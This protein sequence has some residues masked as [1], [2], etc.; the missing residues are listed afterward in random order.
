[1]PFST[2]IMVLLA[3]PFVF[4]SV[5]GGGLGRRVFIGVLIGFMFNLLQTGVGYYALSFGVQPLVAAMTPSLLF[6]G[7]TAA[8]F[9]R[10]R[11]R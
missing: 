3:V 4:G 11:F 9:Y 6:L 8:L 2:L 1:M 10:M 7:L 5:R